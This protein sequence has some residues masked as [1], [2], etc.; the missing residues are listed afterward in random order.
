MVLLNYLTCNSLPTICFNLSYIHIWLC[1]TTKL[2][3]AFQGYIV[4]ATLSKTDCLKAIDF[5]LFN[6]HYK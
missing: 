1:P 6:A 4:L 5:A 2:M 3:L